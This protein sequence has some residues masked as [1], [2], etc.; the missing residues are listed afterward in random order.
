[1]DGLKGFVDDHTLSEPLLQR[2]HFSIIIFLSQIFDVRN[3]FTIFHSRLKD[4]EIGFTGP[5]VVEW[6]KYNFQL[7]LLAISLFVHDDQ[8]TWDG[9]IIKGHIALKEVFHR[10][11]PLSNSLNNKIWF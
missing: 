1:M 7:C 2:L 9:H 6:E 5:L 3:I 4:G 10:L 8:L 11:S